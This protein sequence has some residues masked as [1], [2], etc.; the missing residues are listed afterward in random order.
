M[1]CFFF[2]L[3]HYC[4]SYPNIRKRVRLGK[5]SYTLRLTTRSLPCLTEFYNKFY[6]DRKK[7]IPKDIYNLLTPVA[8]AHLIMG[9]GVAKSHGLLI[10]TDSYT[11]PDIILLIN[12]LIIRYKLDCTL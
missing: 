12:V 9:D 3:S 10:C 4:Q 11:L 5:E 8:L 1:V 2:T 6:V 7:V